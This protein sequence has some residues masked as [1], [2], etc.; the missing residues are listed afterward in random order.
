M[1]FLLSASLWVCS[2]IA[3][4]APMSVAGATTVTT[5]EAHD[6]FKQG[7]LFVDVRR[8]SDWEAG[9]IAGAVHLNLKKTLSEASLAKEAGTDEAIVM[10][11]NGPKCLRSSEACAKAAGWGFNKLYYYRDG[12]PAWK[13]A[14]YAVE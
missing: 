7:A 9:R 2:A 6:L 3:A 5:D 12:F 8:D 4:E 1:I 13:M 10:Y 14:G 11:C